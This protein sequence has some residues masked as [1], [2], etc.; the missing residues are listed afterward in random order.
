MQLQIRLTGLVTILVALAACGGGGA[1]ASTSPAASAPASASTGTSAKPAASGLAS[2]AA[3]PSGGAIKVGYGVLSVASSSLWAAQDEGLFQKDGLNVEEASL[4]SAAL[5]QAIVSGSVP[6]GAGSTANTANAVASGAD[7]RSVAALTQSSSLI[8]AAKP[9]ISTVADLK[10]KTIAVTQPLSTS[11]FITRL[12]LQKNN[13]VYQKDVQVLTAGAT[14][15]QIAAFT[16]GQVQAMTG[17]IDTANQLPAGSYNILVNTAEQNLSFSEQ[18]LVV[19]GA[20]ARAQPQVVATIVKDWWQA[21]LLLLKDYEAFTRVN[22]K[23]LE[24]YS[25]AAVKAGYTIYQKLWSNPANPRVTPESVQTIIDLLGDSNPKIKGMKPSD[26]IDNTYVG[27]LKSQGIFANGGCA[28][29]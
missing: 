24:G 7:I 2:G 15:G 11:D 21:S 14:N 22:K 19:N 10:G 26:V 27:L 16:S 1:S 6:V 23:H 3:Q 25:D 12:V 4:E 18:S 13:L 20:F 9:D 8:I 17:P 29:C 28:G 5:I